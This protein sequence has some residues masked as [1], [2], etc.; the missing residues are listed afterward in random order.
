MHKIFKVIVFGKMWYVNATSSKEVRETLE[1]MG[2]PDKSIWLDELQI[3]TLS[4]IPRRF[5]Y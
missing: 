1:E 5:G 3:S 4:D 2:Y